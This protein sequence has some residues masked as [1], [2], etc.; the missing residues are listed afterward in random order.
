MIKK[1][2]NFLIENNKTISVCE[3]ITAGALS[4]KLI[5]NPGSS[6]FFK[7]SLV[8]YNDEIKNK[9]LKIDLE[10]IKKFSAVS[11]EISLEMAKSVKKIFDSDYSVSTTGNA[12]PQNSDKISKKGGLF[13]T[14]VTPSKIITK[15]YS[16]KD[17]RS[18][19]IQNAVDFAINLL[20]KNLK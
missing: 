4:S 11:K 13:I 16:L 3:S 19:N 20:Y 2:H 8:V 10:K 9:L 1:I 12:G 6:A 15:E 7:G 17:Q 5:S 14:I 18:K